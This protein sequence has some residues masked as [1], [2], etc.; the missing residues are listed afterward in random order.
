MRILCRHG[1]FA[2]YPKDAREVSQFAALFDVDLVRVGDFYTFA[3]LEDVPDFSIQGKTLKGLP[4]TKTFAGHPWEVMR[5]NN[6]VYSLA[7]NA[8]VLK[9]LVVT[10][11]FLQLT[12]DFWI[13]DVP[14]IQPG[15]RIATGQQIL[16]Y[17]AEYIPE[18]SQLR[19]YEVQ[20]A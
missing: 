12:D 5:E 11:I 8:L 13:S 14:I 18:A 20:Y 17:D 10:P 9:S 7:L 15:S 6:F 1:H 19:V 16:S 4:A 3:F 2:F